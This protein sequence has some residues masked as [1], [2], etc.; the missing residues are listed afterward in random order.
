MIRSP[1]VSGVSGAVFV[2]LGFAG[3]AFS[4]ATVPQLYVPVALPGDTVRK[5]STVVVVPPLTLQHDATGNMQL[6]VAFTASPPP[7]PGDGLIIEPIPGTTATRI[8]IDKTFTL[9]RALQP[10]TPS[11]AIGSPCSG[12]AGV[13]VDRMFL[14]VCVPPADQSQTSANPV[15]TWA[16]AALLKAV[17]APVQPSALT[18]LLDG[19]LVA[20]RPAINIV[21][22]PGVVLTA[23]D[24]GAAVTIQISV[25]LPVPVPVVP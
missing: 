13:I 24:T 6:G 20:S 5:S 2:L 7:V 23:V 17:P 15:W 16:G 18:V 11:P 9:Y 4:Q 21:T 8:A 1:G 12:D 25:A 22:G 14:Y 3:A 10:L 19:S